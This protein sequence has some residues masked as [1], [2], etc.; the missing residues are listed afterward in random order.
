VGGWS[1]N[2]LFTLQS[3]QPVPF[4]LAN[5]SIADGTQRPDILCSK[6]LTG[7]S[8]HDLA[9]STDPN[10]SY[11]NSNCF[12]TPADQVPGNARGSPQMRERKVVARIRKL[13]D[14]SQNSGD[15]E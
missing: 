11:Y 5:G 6:L 4:G 2:G 9:F 8:L 14:L 7:M 13:G 10:A 15:F 12:S 3:G 1:L